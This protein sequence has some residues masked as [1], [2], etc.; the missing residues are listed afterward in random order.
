MAWKDGFSVGGLDARLVGASDVQIAVGEP[1]VLSIRL[2][3]RARGIDEAPGPPRPIEGA[4]IASLFVNDS[5]HVSVEDLAPA[6]FPS[7]RSDEHGMLDV[8]YLPKGG[9]VSFR[10]SHRRYAEAKVVYYPVGE[11]RLVLQMVPGIALR[12]RATNEKGE[13]VGRARVSVYRSGPAPLREEQE[14]LTDRE[15]YYSAVVPPGEYYVVAKHSDF[16]SPRPVPVR[17]EEQEAEAVCDLVL[18]KAVRIRGRVVKE[19]DKSAAGVTV[20]YLTNDSI[21]DQT[22]TDNSGEFSL[23]V[24]PGEGRVYVT[25]P[26]GFLC[27]EPA[28][29]LVRSQT[30]DVRLKDAI[31]LV[32]LPEITGVV[33]DPEGRT[34]D[35]VIV[36]SMDL[37]P[38]QWTVSG[39]DGRFALRLVQAPFAGKAR[40]RAEHALRFL[41]AEFEVA[42]NRPRPV[43]LR[44]AEFEPDTSPCDQERVVNKL[45]LLRG[46]P[47]PEWA[48]TKW[49]NAPSADGDSEPA[50]ALAD[51]R[52][53]VVV[54]NFWAGFDTTAKGA[55]RLAELNALYQLLHGRGDVAIVGIHD[56]GNEP[57]EVFEYVRTFQIAY[58]VGID[59]ETS[60]YDA[61]DI[62]AIPQ[63]V[64]IDKQGVLRYYDIE[65]R[66]L[67]LIKA[68]R[69]E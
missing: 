21:Y 35:D 26:D 16:A 43:N 42:L 46:K 48:C 27:E 13:G 44:L 24:A 22:L 32:S 5:Y 15:G 28:G 45:E 2:I 4:R 8:A 59:S 57:H 34:L 1:D 3:E 18:A 58:P 29:I 19:R 63:T 41:R 39:E 6:G 10:V 54:L 52:G 66:L 49:F 11:R 50:L 64:L 53:K 62:F 68:L 9:H 14:T 38:P 60:T 55:G 61:Y 23:Q 31:R 17:V 33:L 47:A 12:G 20:Q 67:E 40:F 7:P 51:L 65:G 25:P 36:A 69:R 30:D 56:G 37:S